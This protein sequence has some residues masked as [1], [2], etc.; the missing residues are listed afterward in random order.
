MKKISNGVISASEALHITHSNNKLSKFDALLNSVNDWIV[1]AANEGNREVA[2]DQDFV[3]FGK[4]RFDRLA[5]F[6][7]AYHYTVQVNLTFENG[8]YQSFDWNYARKNV[9]ILE[10]ARSKKLSKSEMVVRW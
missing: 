8:D 3:K 2:F 5:I 10:E 4:K 9:W 1:D 6:L 7:T